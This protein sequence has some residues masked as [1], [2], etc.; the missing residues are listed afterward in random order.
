MP[1]LL[2]SISSNKYR[3][4]NDHISIKGEDKLKSLKDKRTSNFHLRPFFKF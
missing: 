4:N 2:L 1:Q 3:K